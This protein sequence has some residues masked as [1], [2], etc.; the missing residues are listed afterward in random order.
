MNGVMEP[1]IGNVEKK[2]T[3]NLFIF[4]D[5]EFYTPPGL[6]SNDLSFNFNPYKPGCLLLGGV[7]AR[8]WPL[9]D[10]L[11][12]PKDFWLWNYNGNEGSVARKMFQYLEESRDIVK[13]KFPNDP[14]QLMFCGFSISRMDGAV[15]HIKAMEHKVAK[16]ETIFEIIN[17]SHSIDLSDSTIGFLRGREVEELYPPSMNR[18][19]GYFKVGK[20]KDS[21]ESINTQYENKQFNEIAERTRGEVFTAV[22]CYKKMKDNINYYAKK[23]QQ[24]KNES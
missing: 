12:P 7:I 22:E 17:A 5:L 10:K 13:Q 18:V 24:N 11:E 2:L 19:A 15:L 4:M 20:Q 9:S 1:N 8:Y 16:P 6:R 21:G 23:K 14:T 3:K